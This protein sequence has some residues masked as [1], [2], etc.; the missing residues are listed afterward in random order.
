MRDSQQLAGQT[1]LQDV[2]AMLDGKVRPDSLRVLAYIR[3]YRPDDTAN[4]G[5]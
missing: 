3:C 4:A 1:L 2:I 5:V